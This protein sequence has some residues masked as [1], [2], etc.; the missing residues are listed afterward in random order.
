LLQWKCNN[1]TYYKCVFFF[2]FF[3]HGKRMRRIILYQWSVSLYHNFPHYPINST[4]LG[5]TLMSAKCVFRGSLQLFLKY[6]LFS[7]ELRER[8]RE[9]RSKMYVGLHVKYRCSCRI[10]IKFELFRQI[11]EAHSNTK[12]HANT[13]SGSRVTP[14]RKTDRNR[15]T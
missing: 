3:Q 5:K 13:S 11:F 7:E 12:F 15:R 6:F 9:T 14:C 8:E 4:I 10:L 2:F 1:V